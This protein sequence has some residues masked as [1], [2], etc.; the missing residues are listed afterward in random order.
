MRNSSKKQLLYSI[1]NQKVAS[2]CE[3]CLD[4]ALVFKTGQKLDRSTCD[5][6][7]SSLTLKKSLFQISEKATSNPLQFPNKIINNPHFLRFHSVNF[8]LRTYQYTINQ[9]L[10]TVSL[11]SVMTA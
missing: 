7:H 9:S 1:S 8:F 3:F 4:N 6:R 11:S 5:L 2:S 10:S